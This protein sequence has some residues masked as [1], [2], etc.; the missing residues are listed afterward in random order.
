MPK[1][2]P[3]QIFKAAVRK[4]YLLDAAETL[5]SMAFPGGNRLHALSGGRKGQHAISINA[6]Y[7]LCFEWRVDGV[8]Q[9][10]IV[11]YH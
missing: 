11:D 5:G 4:L 10:E 8:Y 7:R 1:G 6:Q 3:A 9:V 2:F